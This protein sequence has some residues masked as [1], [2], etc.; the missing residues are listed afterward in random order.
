MNTMLR[1]F[2]TVFDDQWAGRPETYGK[3]MAADVYRESDDYFVDID[4]PGVSL[5]DIDIEVEKNTLT[6]SATRPVRESEDREMIM[7]GRPF[8][9]FVRRFFL[10][11]GLDVESIQAS[12]DKGVLTL[13]IPVAD[14]SK[15][16]KIEVLA[17]N[18]AGQIEG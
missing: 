1:R 12:L 14:E 6:V 17:G 9:S 15:A 16:R 4:L 18:N 2:D 5:E 7:R 10:S 3:R 8:G 11:D 13:Q